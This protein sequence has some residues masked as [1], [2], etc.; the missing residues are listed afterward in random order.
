MSETIRNNRRTEADC[1]SMFPDRWSPRSYLPDPI[2]PDQVR[3]LFEA[4]RWAPS[5]YNEQPWLFVAAREPE[6]RA[7]FLETLIEFNQGWAKSAPL[8][9]YILARRAFSESGKP[10]RHAAFDSGAAW[11][12]LA[13]QA[14]KLGLHAHAMAGFDADK[15]RRLLNMDAGE[16]D[17]LA[18]VAVGRRGEPAAL[19]EELR[20]REAPSDRR[21]L[22]DVMRFL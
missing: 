3:V 18:A 1:D 4:A 5:S 20:R 9:V 6:A 19:T 10:N 16:F 12:A 11:M 8:L 15:A 14:R 13:L 17:I 22:A 21:P 7:R 2:P